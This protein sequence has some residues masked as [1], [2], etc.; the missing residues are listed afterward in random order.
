MR[1]RKVHVQLRQQKDTQVHGPEDLTL[2]RCQYS[3]N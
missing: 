3:Q 2:L 1:E